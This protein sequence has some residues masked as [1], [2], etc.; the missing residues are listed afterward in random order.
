[1]ALPDERD[2]VA[3]ARHQA[4]LSQKA[5]DYQRMAECPKVAARLAELVVHQAAFFLRS[6]L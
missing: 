2:I 1:M 3:D 6:S 5:F 4:A